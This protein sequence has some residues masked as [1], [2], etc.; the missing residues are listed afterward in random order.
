MKLVEKLRR[1]GI[2]GREEFKAVLT[3][4]GEFLRRVAYDACTEVFGSDVY[5][6]GLIEFTN[7]CV[8]DCLYCGIRSGNGAAARYRLRVDEILG[9][10]AE[11]YGLGFRTFV[12]QGG[13]DN[14]FTDEKLVEIITKIKE[15]FPD[16]AVT[17]SL[18]ERSEQS[19]QRLF[20]AGG[21]RYLLRHET[22]NEA[23]YAALHPANMRLESRKKCLFALKKIGWQV[24][25]GFM[26]GS[27]GQRLDCIVD[28]LFCIKELNPAMVGIGP[29]IP[30]EKTQFSGEKAGDLQLT[31]N[32]LAVLRLMNPFLLLP[33][34]TAL[35]SIAANGRELGILAGANVVMPNLSPQA[36]RE[37][38][39]LY[40]NKICI[41]D[42]PAHCRGCIGRRVA[43]TGREIVEARG[44]YR[45]V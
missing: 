5:I 23:H 11:G 43:S 20:D 42:E 28:D 1:E 6:R 45:G 26:V 9:C 24:G 13:E 40:D 37:K 15:K 14:F 29:F 25:C 16:C 38:Y 12:L 34:T 7:Y 41:S 27:P 10:C 17:L 22:A 30:H 39:M 36:V 18:G 44:D 35:G 32:A 19:Y 2:L 31:L 8:R 4:D 3:S 33:A 21:D